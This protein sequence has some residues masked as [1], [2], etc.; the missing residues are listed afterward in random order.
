MIRRPSNVPREARFSVHDNWWQVGELRDGKPFGPWK[1]YRP[2]GSPLFEARFDAKGR[3]QGTFKR[4]H[5]DGSLAREAAYSR[6]Q[7]TGRTKLYRAQGASD[8][9]FPC[10]DPRAW[11]IVIEHDGGSEK[12]RR[13]LD[14][15]GVELVDDRTKRS[16]EAMAAMDPVFADANPDGF[17]ASDIAPRV[18]ATFPTAPRVDDDEDDGFLVPVEL[19]P[20][21]P[22]DARRFHNLY[23]EPMTPALRAWHELV[24]PADPRLVGMRVATDADLA[25]EGNLVEALI[26]EHQA[27]PYRAIG[28]RALFS[29]VLPIGHDNHLCY[30]AALCEQPDAPTDAVY[31]LQIDSDAFGTPV[32]RSLDDFAYAVSLITAFDAD[33]VSVP[34]LEA[35]YAKLLGRVDLRGAMAAIE[36]RAIADLDDGETEGDTEGDHREGFYFRRAQLIPAYLFHRSRWLMMLFRGHAEGAVPLYQPGHQGDLPDERFEA[37]LGNAGN[38]WTALYWSFRLLAFADPRLP[39]LLERCADSPAQLARDAASLVGELAAGRK[40]LGAIADFGEVLERFRALDPLSQSSEDDEEDGEQQPDDDSDAQAVPPPIEVPPELQPA[41]DIVQWARDGGYERDNLLLKYEVDVAALGLARRADPAIVSVIAD[42]LDAN[43]WLGWRLLDPWLDGDRADLSALLPRAR[44]WLRARDTGALYKWLAGARIIARAGEPADG[45]LINEVLELCLDDLFG[46]GQGFEAAMGSMILKE[47]IEPLCAAAITAGISESLIAA[48]EGVASADTHLVDDSR[49]PCAV[50]LA[51]VGRGLD[52]IVTG[53][54]G[55]LERKHG[56]RITPGQ[57]LALGTLGTLEPERAGELRELIESIPRL[58][59]EAKLA[60]SIAL[61]DLGAVEAEA[62]DL[63]AVVRA[64]LDRR[65]YKDGREDAAKE[66]ARIVE[67]IER[68]PDLPGDLAVPYVRSEHVVLH[69]AA[70]RAL[71]A[72]GLPVPEYQ[73][74]DPYFVAELAERGREALHAA[75][76]DEGAAHVGN[77]ALWIADN[78]DESSREPLIAFVERVAARG[79]FPDEGPRHYDLRWALRTLM[80]L[81]GADHVLEMLLLHD[82]RDLAEPLLRYPELLPPAVA[83][84]MAH[85]F[86]TDQ[87]WRQGVAREWLARHKDDPRIA[88]ALAELGLAIEDLRRE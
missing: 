5:P 44:D 59:D 4:F 66:R 82:E 33:A 43:P 28:L 81:G 42:V 46:R 11:Q 70:V 40:Q 63:A 29:G 48:L 26:A 64:E 76:A 8:D 62:A 23:G 69:R 34:G 56:H 51:S 15:R 80:Q 30:G 85:V 86:A 1:T 47:A 16:S 22:I 77:V 38:P 6:G 74:Y 55:Q 65:R 20:R 2:D 75:L 45:Q 58:S 3:L 10:T 31:P 54:R 39:R 17:L 52:A 79:G 7:S 24:T 41:A 36:Q 21:R 57:L 87:H 72:R 19:P 50:A 25:V 49:G 37:I 67:L 14:E 12:S 84:G 35:A 78:P 27:A 83:R 71:Q 88:A 61:R 53:L 9:V 68:R 18:F 60:R 13:L 73:I 32:A